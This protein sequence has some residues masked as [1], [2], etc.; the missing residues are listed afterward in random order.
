M[1]TKALNSLADL[2][3]RAQEQDR[4]PMGIA[5]A[6]DAAGRHMSPETAA[7]LVRLRDRIA[8]LETQTARV[9]TE[10]LTP[11]D[12]VWGNHAR[13][14]EV[15]PYPHELESNPWNTGTAMRITGV[16]FDGNPLVLDALASKEW[17]RDAP[18]E[19]ARLRTRIA[20]LESERHVTNEALSDAAEA[21]RVGRDRIAEL[22]AERGAIVAGRDA[23]IIAWL[24]KKA[25]E[26][27]TSN[28][29]KRAKAEAVA[30]TADKLSRGAVRPDA[31]LIAT[32]ELV[33]ADHYKD[34]ARLLED[35]GRDDDSVNFLDLMADGIREHATEQLASREDPHDSPLRTDYRLGHDLPEYPHA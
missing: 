19:L 35:T 27:G 30:R 33:R 18:S 3:L 24:G 12:R 29:E 4:T 13:F 20:E 16:D 8:Q 26:Y 21:L 2:I 17:V 28:A 25:G 6:V 31:P 22:E 7:E 10:D 1:N 34:A 11:G 32:R 9:R 5:I 14:I 23:Q 15:G